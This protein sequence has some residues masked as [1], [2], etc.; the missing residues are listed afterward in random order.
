MIKKLILSGL[1]VLSTSVV[2]HTYNELLSN[3]DYTLVTL[4]A[5]YYYNQECAGVT[6]IGNL[7]IQKA[8]KVH[9]LDFATID[10]EMFMLGWGEV[11]KISCNQIYIEFDNLGVR[12]FLRKKKIY[13]KAR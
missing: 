4:G 10:D 13:M 6:T 7:F 8:V 1:L 2:A 11:E 5:L 12:E 9:D 3:R